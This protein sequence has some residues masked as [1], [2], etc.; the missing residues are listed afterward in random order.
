MVFGTIIRST[1]GTHIFIDWK[2]PLS[3]INF[4]LNLR[5][6]AYRDHDGIIEYST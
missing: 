4:G 5:K 1:V 2:V 3:I 6:A